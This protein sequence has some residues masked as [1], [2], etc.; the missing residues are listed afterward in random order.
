MRWHVLLTIT[1][2]AKIANDQFIHFETFC[3]YKLIQSSPF[4][5]DV[6]FFKK[7]S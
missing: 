6:S 1:L 7:Y 5:L 3:A 2:F 4:E